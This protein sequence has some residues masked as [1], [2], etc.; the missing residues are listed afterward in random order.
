MF[1][2]LYHC[3]LIFLVLRLESVY[4][5]LVCLNRAGDFE[6]DWGISGREKIGLAQLGT[7]IGPPVDN[8]FYHG[9]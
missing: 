8:V 7:W 6:K 5:S 2:K 4:K 3:F 1:V 9:N